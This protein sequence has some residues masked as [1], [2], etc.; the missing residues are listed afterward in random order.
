MATHPTLTFLKYTDATSTNTSIATGGVCTLTSTVSANTWSSGLAMRLKFTRG[1]AFSVQNVRIWMNDTSATLNGGEV[2]ISDWDF[3]YK[4][5][6]AAGVSVGDMQSAGVACIT[7]AITTGD[8]A[9]WAALPVDSVAN[10]ITLTDMTSAIGTA[11]TI[12][13]RFIGLSFRPIVS[14]QDGTYTNFSMQS[15]YEFS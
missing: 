9:G 2:D 6:G 5:T 10:A 3:N 13:S 4:Y 8:Q 15:R 7:E 12:Y 14:A 11:T 1:S